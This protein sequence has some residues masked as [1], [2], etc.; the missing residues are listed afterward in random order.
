MT[1]AWQAIPRH[2]APALAGPA[3]SHRLGKPP[4]N[5]VWQ[6]RNPYR[7]FQRKQ[8]SPDTALL[9][10]RPISRQGQRPCLVS[11]RQYPAGH[12]LPS[13]R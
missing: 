5:R 7:A 9:E 11:S 6:P 4:G 3:A 8:L 2:N 1:A 10:T 12:E 13:V